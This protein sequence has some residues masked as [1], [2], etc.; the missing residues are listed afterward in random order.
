MDEHKS[1]YKFPFNA[2]EILSGENTYL[3]DKFFEDSNSQE[4]D[5]YEALDEPEKEQIEEVKKETPIT[6]TDQEVE[7]IVKG[8]NEMELQNNIVEGEDSKEEEIKTQEVNLEDK[9]N[10][11]EKKVDPDSKG[12]KSKCEENFENKIIVKVNEDVT[13]EISPENEAKEKVNFL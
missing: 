3:L 8:V 5:H 1:G 2:A 11:E 4:E 12:E 13:Q 7:S 9:E 10:Q 6:T